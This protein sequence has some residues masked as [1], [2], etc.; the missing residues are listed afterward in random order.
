MSAREDVAIIRTRLECAKAGTTT[1]A[2]EALARL[3]ATLPKPDF[4]TGFYQYATSGLYWYNAY[5]DQWFDVTQGY[6]RTD[7]PERLHKGELMRLYRADEVSA[8]A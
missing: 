4:E 3:E 5:T 1:E 6:K 8:L 7:Y 2:L